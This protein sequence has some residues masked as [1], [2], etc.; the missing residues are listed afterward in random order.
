MGSG[1]VSSLARMLFC[2][3][4]SR[5]GPGRRMLVGAGGLSCP[6]QLWGNPLGFPDQTSF[7]FR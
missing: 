2:R 4:G 6:P 5:R 1:P 7:F 3:C